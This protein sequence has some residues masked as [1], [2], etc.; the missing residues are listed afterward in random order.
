[1]PQ[2]THAQ[3]AELHNIAAHAHKRAAASHSENDHLSAHEMSTDAFEK[4]REAHQHA[5]NLAH[6]ERL[7][8]A[9]KATK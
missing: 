8:K 4:S 5:E 2:S 3:V 1:M 7:A 9:T 6:Q